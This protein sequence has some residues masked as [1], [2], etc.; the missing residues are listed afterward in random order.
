[1]R[2]R[3]VLQKYCRQN[4]SE[5]TGCGHNNTTSVTPLKPDFKY[6]ESKSID[7]SLCVLRCQMLAGLLRY[8]IGTND[9]KEGVLIYFLSRYES[10]ITL[11]LKYRYFHLVRFLFIISTANIIIYP[12]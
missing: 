6:N 12:Q 9:V 2:K 4:T 7:S 3:I 5:G 10:E 8:R 1:M 11:V